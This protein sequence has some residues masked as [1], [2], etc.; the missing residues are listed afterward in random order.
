MSKSR[1]VLDRFAKILE[2]GITNY[3]DISEELLNLCK[4]KRDEI[5]FR[6][7]LVGKEEVEVLNKRISKLEKQLEELKKK[8]KKK[9]KRAK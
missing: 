8:N 3:K 7:K 9:T 2:Q 1:F 4:S 6:M 5:I